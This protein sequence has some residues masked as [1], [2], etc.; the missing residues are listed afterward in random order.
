MEALRHGAPLRHVRE[1]QMGL[2]C[3]LETAR[4]ATPVTEG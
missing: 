4:G 2:H 3:P 1:V